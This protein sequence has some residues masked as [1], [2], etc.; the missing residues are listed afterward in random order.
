MNI[1]NL[2]VKNIS[3]SNTECS[4]NSI[5]TNGILRLSRIFKYQFFRNINYLNIEDHLSRSGLIFGETGIIF[6][7]IFIFII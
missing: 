5:S 2:K 7:K 1:K 3:V 4:P 6:K